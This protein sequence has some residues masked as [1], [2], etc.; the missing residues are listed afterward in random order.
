MKVVV[1]VCHDPVW[2]WVIGTSH[3]DDMMKRPQYRYDVVDQHR[4]VY[5]SLT[6]IYVCMYAAPT[7]CKKGPL[8]SLIQPTGAST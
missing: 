3:G 7:S 1:R 2:V 5:I 4:H 6:H 8:G